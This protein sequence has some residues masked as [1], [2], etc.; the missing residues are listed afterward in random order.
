MRQAPIERNVQ[1]PVPIDPHSAQAL[2]TLHGLLLVT[3]CAAKP[4]DTRPGSPSP[5]AAATAAAG[6][7]PPA[8][9]PHAVPGL[10]RVSLDLEEKSM[11]ALA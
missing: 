8:Q 7:G 10:G 1:L 3:A 11:E 4:P 2:L 9:A 5:A 6:E